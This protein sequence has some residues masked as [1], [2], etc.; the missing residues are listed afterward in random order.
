MRDR[1]TYIGGGDIACLCGVG[2]LT[3]FQVWM[4][5]LGM[6]EDTPS[7]RMRVG[8]ELEDFILKDYAERYQREL[9]DVQRHFVDDD[10]EYFGGTVDAIVEIKDVRVVV[11]AKTHSGYPFEDE[12][13]AGYQ[14]QGQWY[15]MLTGASHAEF[16]V[17]HFGL[18][19]FR[20]YSVVRDDA[21]IANLRTVGHAF[22]E[23]VIDGTPPDYSVGDDA[24][25]WFASLKK[26]TDEYWADDEMLRLVDA[27]IQSREIEKEADKEAQR[28]RAEIQNRMRTLPDYIVNPMTDERLLKFSKKDDG[29]LRSLLI[30]KKRS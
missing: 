17:L 3:P 28:Y 10:C 12:L 9:Q 20:T 27:Y 25:S 14:I 5:K 23:H 13:P 4:R 19:D 11:D 30:Q 16:H 6:A 2:F 21:M 1:K 8:L 24:A 7:V 18:G 15:M 26:T 29:T 22:W